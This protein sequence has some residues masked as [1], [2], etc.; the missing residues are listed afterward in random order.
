VEVGVF[1]EGEPYM[2]KHRIRSGQQTITMTVPRKPIR[3]G[4]DPQSL[5]IDLDPEDNIRDVKIQN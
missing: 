2:E 1:G 5:L 3:A 4:I